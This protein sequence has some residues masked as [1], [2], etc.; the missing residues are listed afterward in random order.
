MVFLILVPDPLSLLYKRF[1]KIVT[2]NGHFWKCMLT[3]IR[4]VKFIQK[5]VS[6]QCL[7]PLFVF[8]FWSSYD[9][10]YLYRNGFNTFYT[11]KILE[12]LPQ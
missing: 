9:V 6:L 5:C 8:Y 2:A 11:F 3:S 1:V 7:L 4:N 12:F 10:P